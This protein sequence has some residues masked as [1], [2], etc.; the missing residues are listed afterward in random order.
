MKHSYLTGSYGPHPPGGQ[1]YVAG[2]P[3][4][5]TVNVFGQLWPL[6]QVSRREERA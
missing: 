4:L 5:R 3:V 1:E 6:V 2:W